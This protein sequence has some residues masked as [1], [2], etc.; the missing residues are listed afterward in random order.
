MEQIV[1]LHNIVMHTKVLGPGIRTAIWFQG[2][3]RRC[4][5]CMSPVSRPLD[6]GK[7]VKLNDVIQA[8]IAEPGIEGVTI[9]GGEPFLQIEA[10]YYFLK[11]IKEQSV[12]GVIIYSGFTLK[13][14][15]DMNQPMVDEII[16]GLADIIIDGEYVDELN[17]GKALK[18][19]ANQ[20][21]HFITDRYLAYKDIYEQKKRNAEVIA[22][23]KDIFFIGIPAKDTLTEWKNVTEELS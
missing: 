16:S 9:S 22:T 10:L 5:G 12:L 19:S 11:S 18:G 13:E 4:K 23:E 6:G 21:V 1:R 8:V 20:T 14:L 17:D 2:C 3:N 7:L 15:E